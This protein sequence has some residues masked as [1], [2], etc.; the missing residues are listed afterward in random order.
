MVGVL[1]VVGVVLELPVVASD[2]DTDQGIW[3]RGKANM[4][5]IQ[6]ETL[7]DFRVEVIST[8][9]YSAHPRV[10]ILSAW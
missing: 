8:A 2:Y 7:K 5:Y 9:R 4:T 6:Y 1:S 3:I 10:R